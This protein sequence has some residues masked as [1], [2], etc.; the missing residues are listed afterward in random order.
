MFQVVLDQKITKLEVDFPN[1]R[2]ANYFSI[3]YDKFRH[4]MAFKH[5]LY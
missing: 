4:F 5:V 3:P 2:M 1:E